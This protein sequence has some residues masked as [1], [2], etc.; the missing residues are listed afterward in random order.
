[1]KSSKRENTFCKIA[2]KW[3]EV[4]S[5]KL[6][7]STADKIWRNLELHLFPYIGD[8]L[9]HEITAQD[10]IHVLQP[11]KTQGHFTVIQRLCQSLNRIMSFGVNTGVITHNPLTGIKDAF[12]SPHSRNHRSITPDRLPELMV[13][14]Q[15]SNIQ[16]K[17]R[18]LVEFQL[19][20][21]KAS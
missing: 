20:N 8:K 12:Q 1:M 3:F 10:T 17:I 14:L 2:E 21:V 19:H 15:S 11:I 5:V 9:L 13:A 4:T 7:A 6:Q 16:I 18:C